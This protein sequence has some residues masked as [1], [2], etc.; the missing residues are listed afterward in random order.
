LEKSQK[1]PSSFAVRRSAPIID[2]G[3]SIYGK[4]SV[5]LRCEPL[6]DSRDELITFAPSS[7]INEYVA[8]DTVVVRILPEDARVRRAS[9]HNETPKLFVPPDAGTNAARVSHGQRLINF[10]VRV[11]P[12][13]IER[14]NRAGWHE[15]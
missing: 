4:W 9:H 7:G 15:E 13:D 5:E 2:I 1:L 3:K 10:F 11:A 6:V 14:S 8:L 12:S